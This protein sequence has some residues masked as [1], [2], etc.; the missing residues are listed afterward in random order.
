VAFGHGTFVVVGWHEVILASADGGTR[1][2]R[3]NSGATQNL[4]QVCFDLS[5]ESLAALAN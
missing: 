4:S 2:T 3:M 1:W 5:E